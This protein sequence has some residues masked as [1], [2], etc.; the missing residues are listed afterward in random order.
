MFLHTVYIIHTVQWAHI[1]HV[2]LRTCASMC[3]GVLVAVKWLSDFCVFLM[4]EYICVFVFV[5]DPEGSL[6]S[7]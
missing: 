4:H 6:I 1:E 7:Q 5:C 2:Y 3:V